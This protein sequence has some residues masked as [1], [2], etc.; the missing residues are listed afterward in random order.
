MKQV[1][2]FL[3]SVTYKVALTFAACATLNAYAVPPNVTLPNGL[4]LGSTSFLDGFGGNPGDFAIQSYLT[5][6]HAD[7]YKTNNGSNSPLFN[8][9][10]VNVTSLVEQFLYNFPTTTTVLGGHPGVDL[11]VPLVNLDSSFSP[12]P[13]Y[14]GVMLTN[15]HTGLGD[16]NA[17]VSLQWDPVM[18]NGHPVFVSRAE[19]YGSMPTGKYDQSTDLNPGNHFWGVGIMGSFTFLLGPDFEVS[20]RPHYQYSFKNG[21]PASSAPLDPGINDTQAGQVIYTNFAASYKVTDKLRAGINGYFLRQITDNRVNGSAIAD[22]REQVLG[23]GPGLYYDLRR[24]DKFW[25]NTYSEMLVRN[26][27]RNAAIVNL[28]WIHIF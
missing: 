27:F 9:P 22:S 25:L 2:E 23:I 10:R 12:P 15:G 16:I 5:T 4:D 17:G 19:V 13:P 21:S 7:A 3:K 6:S 11:I 14:P 18:M 1:G 28:R 24:G 20:L 8:D 26:R